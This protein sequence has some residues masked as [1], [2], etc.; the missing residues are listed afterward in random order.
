MFKTLKYMALAAAMAVLPMS[1]NALIIGDVTTSNPFSQTTFDETALDVVDG[2]SLGD[3]VNLPTTVDAILN[4]Q[5]GGFLDF[6]VTNMSAIDQAFAIGS[7]SV[8]QT[9]GSFGTVGAAGQ[10]ITF[11]WLGSGDSEFIAAGD[12]TPSPAPTLVSALLTAGSSDTLRVMF[13]D[14]KGT[15][16]FDFQVQAV[17]LPASLVLFLSALGGLGLLGRRRKASSVA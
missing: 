1:A 7:I 13:D 15:A 12:A 5:A 11:T 9:A 6:V 10:G 16:S 2:L 17:P 8:L 3:V 4:N 14:V